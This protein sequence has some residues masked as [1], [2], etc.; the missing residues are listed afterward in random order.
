MPFAS[1]SD[2]WSAAIERFA[3]LRGLFGTP[4]AF[5][6]VR[7]D[8]TRE[9]RDEV[10]AY[11]RPLERLLRCA[12]VLLAHREPVA[13]APRATR[14]GERIPGRTPPAAPGAESNE[15]RGVSFSVLPRPARPRRRARRAFC[16]PP[17]QAF[18][19]YPLAKRMEAIAR[20]MAAPERWIRRLARWL[21][22]RMNDARRALRP[23]LTRDP[24]A[25]PDVADARDALDH[26]LD[27]S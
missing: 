11:L 19:R 17:P 3:W 8:L 25:P 9:A 4:F 14:R 16:S 24:R 20:V 6:S 2:I 1:L 5:L 10:L 21:R 27:T 23:L 26:A 13:P 12:L 18:S 7:A 22:T 15:W